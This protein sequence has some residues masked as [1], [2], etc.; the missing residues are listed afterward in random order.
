[1]KTRAGFTAVELAVLALIIGILAAVCPSF[2]GTMGAGIL[3]I[4]LAA[5]VG[6][7]MRKAKL[8]LLIAVLGGLVT[9]AT[10]VYFLAKGVDTAPGFRHVMRKAHA[11]AA[12]P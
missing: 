4:G 5:V 11:A 1:M 7:L 8:P 6:K 3:L 2:N 9:A 12:R 10:G